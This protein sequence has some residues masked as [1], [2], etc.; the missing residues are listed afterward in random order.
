MGG[1][2]AVVSR[3][4][5]ALAALPE[6]TL[7]PISLEGLT[8]D[9]D[10]MPLV[11]AAQEQKAVLD[12]L[13]EKIGNLTSG[14]R[15]HFDGRI[16]TAD[17]KQIDTNNPLPITGALSLDA[18]EVLTTQQSPVTP[19]PYQTTGI[20][21][22]DTVLA[23]SAGMRLRLRKFQLHMDPA[24]TADTYNTVT[25]EFPST[26]LTVFHDKF[27]PGLPYAE[28]TWIEGATDEALVITTTAASVIYVNVRTEEFA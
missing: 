16:R 15:S 7:P 8:A 12:A 6:L 5:Q 20:E 14:T 17:A 27:E 4:E 10:L 22:Q 13:R 9:V 2:V 21:T 24:A 25:L 28:E 26:G 23:P 18:D 3:I 11:E 1:L 19:T